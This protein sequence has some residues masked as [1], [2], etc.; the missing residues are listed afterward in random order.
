M[1]LKGHRNADIPSGLISILNRKGQCLQRLQKYG[2][3]M[4]R[5]HTSRDKQQHPQHLCLSI[6]LCWCQAKSH[7]P[8][9]ALF[10]V[11][12]NSHHDALHWQTVA[13]KGNTIILHLQFQDRC[14]RTL[15]FLSHLAN[16]TKDP[17]HISG[18]LRRGSKA[19]SCI[20]ILY[21]II[22]CS[23]VLK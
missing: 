12:S 7:L 22:L 23:H 17:F 16:S 18:L 9:L 21:Y 13:N 6:Q 4:R 1:P 2:R 15:V 3:L 5:I 14:S 8:D 11:F 19:Y 20:I 10:I